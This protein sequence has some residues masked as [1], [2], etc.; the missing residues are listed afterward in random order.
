MTH[1][2]MERF[3]KKCTHGRLGLTFQNESYVVTVSYGYDKG[4]I[5]FHS[6]MQ[7]KKVDF[8]KNNNRVC[9]EVYERQ[10]G[11]ASVLC[12]G[13]VALREDIEAKREFSEVH[14]GRKQSDEELEKL[15]TY[16]GVIEIE[17]MTGRYWIGAVKSPF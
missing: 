11:W 6:G 7:G 10:D 8:I 16:I 5:Y 14:L 4:K 9:F 13:T 1:D 15:T 17:E 3:L 2:E 12:Y